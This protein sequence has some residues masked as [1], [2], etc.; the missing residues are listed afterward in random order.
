MSKAMRDMPAWGI[1]LVI[2][3]SILAAFNYIVLESQKDLDSTTITSVV[4]DKLQEE[5]LRF[6]E[7]AMDQV[8]T[9]GT[10]VSMSPS[11]QVATAV[12]DKAESR[13]QEFDEVF[14][15]ELRDFASESI[16]HTSE[17]LAQ[18]F[19]N[20]GTSDKVEGGV[21]G[22]LDRAAYEIRNS[23]RSRKTMVIWLFDASG[24]L[25]E[26]REAVANRFD[27][28]YKQV[29]ETGDTDSLYTVI[30][31]FGEKANLHTPEPLQDS[32]KLSE[33][34][35]KEIKKDESGKEMVFSAAKMTLEKFQNW[36]RSKGPWNKLVFIITDEKG[37]DADQYLESVITLGKRTN[38]RFFTIGNA[39]IFGQLKGYV[40]YTF[41]DG[42]VDY[43][44]V[45]QGPESAFPDAVQLPFIGSGQ[46][47]KLKQMSS[48]YGPYALTRLCAE[49]G[50]MYLI[51]Q[52]TRGYNFD[53]AIMRRY[54][55]DYR[56]VRV[57][58]Q[59][60]AKNGAKR[61]LVNVAEMTYR[62]SS[63]IPELTF[64]GYNDN[65]LRTDITEAQKPVAE[66]DYELK[67]LYDGLS[68][69]TKDRDALREPRWQ[70]AFD[71]AMGRIL[72][73]RVR[74]FGYNTMLANMRVTP[75]PFADEKSN[76]WRLVPS[77]EI[78]TGPEMRKAAASAKEYL[79]RVIDDHPG[80]PW[81]ML[82]TRELEMDLG[83]S[84]EEYSEAIP[85]SN[86]MLRANQEEVARL[87]LADEERR[88][89]ARQKAAKPRARPKL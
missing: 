62:S 22:A 68:T 72:A 61:A 20:K 6:N 45:D 35:R 80:T 40:E 53:R 42:Y 29:G 83:W 41:E 11:L 69:G 10:G 54:A 5:E 38:T 34:V 4:D 27:N 17:D 66:I 70:A 59:E 15:P 39:A 14:N 76:M 37:D 43:L 74:Y 77:D 25:D 8:G 3:L 18:E 50:G 51:T 33:I 67:R 87:L 85:G 49:T 48:S 1:S 9:D 31:S 16:D 7:T 78:L 56:P 47:W 84:W 21:E 73:M 88:E 13:E 89:V 81:A 23:L 75:K 71:L 64:R 63:P 2:N 46:D 19:E 82:A 57:I 32:A 44:P 28:I 65:I 30:A 36:H 52:E 60:I 58:K 55:P 79:K 12:A 24:S 86:G 26:R